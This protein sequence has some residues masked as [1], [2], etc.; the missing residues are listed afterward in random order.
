[1]RLG[2]GRGR[3]YD[4]RETWIAMLLADE[5]TKILGLPSDTY[6][7]HAIISLADTLYKISVN[8]YRQIEGYRLQELAKT[9][10]ILS[11]LQTEFSDTTITP[12]TGAI[13]SD[14]VRYEG[15]IP[16][17]RLFG[18]SLEFFLSGERLAFNNYNLKITRDTVYSDQKTTKGNGY[19][20][21]I[22]LIHRYARPINSRWQLGSQILM[23]ARRQH[24]TNQIIDHLNSDNNGPPDY[25]P[26]RYR[27]T[28]HLSFAPNIWYFHNSRNMLGIVGVFNINYGWE[29]FDPPGDK[30]A[31]PSDALGIWDKVVANGNLTLSY[32]N[33]LAGNMYFNSHIRLMY[34][35][36]SMMKSIDNGI[37]L[38]GHD[39]RASFSA[40]L[41]YYF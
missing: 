37:R 21:Q 40:S 18:S 15:G 3:L 26:T 32:K 10:A 4:G 19:D 30:V 33:L 39:L 23:T 28:T 20:Y 38:K 24:A 12:S 2:L 16:I 22:G 35:K 36:S 25:W 9:E 31:S 7:R 8:K 29:E 6:D 34:H 14:I 17:S 41:T 5:I 1:M 13:I 11:F 27:F